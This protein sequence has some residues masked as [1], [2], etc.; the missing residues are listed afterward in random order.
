MLIFVTWKVCCSIIFLYFYFLQRILVLLKSKMVCHLKGMLLY[1]GGAV[2]VKRQ[3][4]GRLFIKHSLLTLLM[5]AK[6]HVFKKCNS[7]YHLAL[8]V[9]K[10]FAAHFVDVCKNFHLQ[11]GYSTLFT[12]WCSLF[13]RHSVLTWWMQKL[14]SSK[15]A[16][17]YLYQAL[18]LTW[19]MQNLSWGWFPKQ[20]LNHL[21]SPSKW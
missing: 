8:S 12:I 6:T 18:V 3:N 15:T 4:I 20:P 9:Y 10:A 11:K 16:F 1:C 21:T 17:N 5:F 14:C 13:I 19:L 2:S 7:L